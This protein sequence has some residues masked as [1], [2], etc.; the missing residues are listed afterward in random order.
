LDD[1]IHAVDYESL[2]IDNDP[3]YEKRPIRILT[4]EVKVFYTKKMVFIKPSNIRNYVKK[5]EIGRNTTSNSK[6]K[7]LLRRK[8][9]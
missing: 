4:C 5:E 1:L 7:I 9:F 3:R 8:F 6:I 2:Q